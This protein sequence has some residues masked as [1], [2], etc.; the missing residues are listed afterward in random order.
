M[1][2]QAVDSAAD[3]VSSVVKSSDSAGIG[4]VVKV[5]SS[6]TGIDLGN[7]FTSGGITLAIL[8]GSVA[9]LRVVLDYAVE[10]LKRKYIVT[11]D[12]ESKDESYTWILN[13]L[14]D[15]PLSATTTRFTVAT[16]IS[17]PGEA[18]SV[19]EVA[20]R[21]VWQQGFGKEFLPKVFFL[22]S[23]G[24]HL[25]R[26][27]SHLLYLSRAR[28]TLPG[29][30]MPTGSAAIPERISISAF[31]KRE[32]LERLVHEAQRKWLEI[33]KGRTVI[34]AAD[35]YGNWRRARSRP[36]RPLS[37]I[38]LDRGL[39]TRIVSD[40]IEFLQSERWYA[41]RGIPYRRGYLFYGSPGTGK[42]SFITALAGHLRFNI[43]VISLANRGLTDD[44]LVE[45]MSMTPPR[46]I[47]LLEDVDAAFRGKRGEAGADIVGQAG[48][49]L[50]FS[51]LLNAIDGVAAQEGRILCMTTNHIDQ[52]DPALI[53]PGR[54]DVRV[55][56][57]KASAWQAR[58]LFVNFYARGDV[59]PPMVG[60]EALEGVESGGSE[61]SYG[62]GQKSAR[63]DN[64]DAETAT[65]EAESTPAVVL[66]SSGVVD[67]GAYQVD[68]RSVGKLADE[69]AG[70][71]PE[72][73]YSAAQL[74][75]YLMDF[76][77]DPRIAIKR[78]PG[79]LESNT[80]DTKKQAM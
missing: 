31:G 64:K 52:L 30:A 71:I 15:H 36:I 51:G 75:V 76:K 67:Q 70:K 13:F 54:I 44:N 37:T 61:V 33:E 57:D 4:A 79:F 77:Y 55:L 50:T 58:E 28:P 27:H 68:S 7:Q 40:V 65:G 62:V 21:S 47:L 11:A 66:G 60:E 80:G 20:E 39:K 46:C 25:F 19:N 17:K 48:N 3:A 41:D 35:Q 8:G 2:N 78:L 72:R 14:A 63:G 56:F 1:S 73:T 42:T 24:S 22:P 26:F 16:D 10:Y 9:A 34:Y 38:V 6:S 69:F 74:Q 43:Y 18:R 49:S 5:F 23:Q 12:F 59:A 29:G 32:I 53:R 45:L